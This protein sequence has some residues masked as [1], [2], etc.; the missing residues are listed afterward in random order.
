MSKTESDVEGIRRIA[1]AYQKSRVLLSAFELGIFSE[2]GEGPRSSA[3]TARAL[4][5]DPRATD[6]LMNALCAMELLKKSGDKFSNTPATGRHLDRKKPDYLAGLQHTAHLWMT[7]SGLTEAV[8]KGTAVAQREV[9]ARGDEWLE[10]FIAQMHSR[11]T[12][13]APESVA[14]LDLRGVRRVLDVGGGSGAFAVA[15]AAAGPGI[16]ATVFDLPNVIPLAR[17]YVGRSGLRDRVDFATGDYARDE[18]GSGFDLVFLSA[19]IHS[20]T[21][22]ENEGLIRKCA[23]A[24][25]PGGSVVV[26]DFIMDDARTGPLH[27]ALFALN[28]LVGTDG[29]DTYTETEVRAWM[30]QAGLEDVARI[31]TQHDTT[32]IIGRKKLYA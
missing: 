20:N 22:R 23:A 27:G 14:C 21:A 25:N 2:L 3:E 18:L 32:Q 19:V 9:N 5:T 11:A 29:G 1:T 28:M 13:N 16:R 15:F 24:L 26:E 12:A 6:R 30:E 8:R 31:E 7:W 4:K 10:A 17:S